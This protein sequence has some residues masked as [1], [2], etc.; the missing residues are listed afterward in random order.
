MLAS[1][2]ARLAHRRGTFRFWRSRASAPIQS[3][4]VAG[5]V[6]P[7]SAQVLRWSTT[8]HFRLRCFKQPKKYVRSTSGLE[9]SWSTI[10]LSTRS[11]PIPKQIRFGPGLTCD[12]RQKEI[13]REGKSIFAVRD[14]EYSTMHPRQFFAS[15]Y[16]LCL[17]RRE[18]VKAAHHGLL[19]CKILR[20]PRVS[21]MMP[22]FRFE[23]R[24]IKLRKLHIRHVLRQHMKSLA[25][26]RFDNTRHKQA[27]DCPLWFLFSN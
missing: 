10:R 2:R 6:I 7:S 15:D 14:G 5:T 11:P 13:G 16:N 24:T 3:S 27:I 18:F 19:R 17:S 8:V 25:R 9:L 4:A 12:I 20:Q 23:Q 22:R 21:R 1:S 26:S